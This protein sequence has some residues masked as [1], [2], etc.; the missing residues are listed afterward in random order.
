MANTT[1]YLEARLADLEKRHEDLQR[2]YERAFEGLI[3][4]ADRLNKL[5]KEPLPRLKKG[6][7][8]SRRIQGAKAK[9]A[10]EA[11]EKA[12]DAS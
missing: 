12:K 10:K 7:K 1:E 3:T 8:H 11:A 5:E 2:R 4:F 9:K 6:P